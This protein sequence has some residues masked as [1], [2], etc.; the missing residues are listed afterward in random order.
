[1]MIF[2]QAL[3]KGNSANLAFM[4]QQYADLVAN[5]RDPRH[6][7]PAEMFA[8]AGKRPAD[9]YQEFD[10]QVVEQFHLD[11]GDA[12]L[13]RLMP[14]ARSLPIGR[15]VLA[16][17]RSS[18]S[19]Q[20]QTSMSGEIPVIYDNVD[21]DTDKAIV[22][23]HQN[24]FKRNWR[25]GEQMSLEGFMDAVIQQSEAVRTHRKGVVDYM[26]DGSD[27]THDGVTWAGFRGDSRVDQVDLGAGGVN[28]D[29]TDSAQTGEDFVAAWL[30]LAERRYITNRVAAP[31]T[32]FVSNEIWWNMQRDYSAAKGDNTILDRVRAIVTVSEIVPSSKLVGNQVLSMPLSRDFVQPL[33][34][35]AVSTIALPR[36][37]YRDPF[38]FDVVS[39]IGVQVKSDF[40]SGN[41]AVQYASS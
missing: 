37:N 19:G 12:I 7:L 39:A 5:R 1:M 3:A 24:G 21:Y 38:A 29:F 9:L 13:S 16:N 18:D 41:T 31:A 25:E 15:T 35:M 28:F 22:P 20:F 2:N 11:E 4:K 27:I 32:W 8:N 23:I 40:E 34:G 26:L 6:A 17:A 10:D 30:T 14:L 36:L 33:V